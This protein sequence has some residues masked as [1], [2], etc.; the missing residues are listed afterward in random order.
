MKANWYFEKNPRHRSQPQKSCLCMISIS[1]DQ[2]VCFTEYILYL[3]FWVVKRNEY[4]NVVIIMASVWCDFY[5]FVESVL[6][7]YQ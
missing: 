5:Q 1:V 7:H 6:N 3:T 2:F 4:H